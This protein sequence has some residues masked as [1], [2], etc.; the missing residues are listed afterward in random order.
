[1]GASVLVCTCPIVTLFGQNVTVTQDV[2]T[3]SASRFPVRLTNF[4]GRVTELRDV[5]RALE[6]HRLV[7]LVG[8]GGSGKTRLAIEAARS[9]GERRWFVDLASVE[10]GTGV[11]AELAAATDAPEGPGENPLDATVRR[12]AET[13]ALLLLDNCDQVVAACARTVDVLLRACPSL[14]VLATSREP[15]RVEGEHAWRVPP[16]SLP[17]AGESLDGDAVLLFLDRAGL[18]PDAA[19][20]DLEQ[21]H[22]ICR[23][24]DGMPLAIE[25]AASRATVLPVTDILTGLSDR[26]RLL[27]GGPRTTDTRQQSLAESIRWSYRLLTD[28]ERRVLQRLA[29]FRGPFTAE[30]TRA[31]AAGEGIDERDVLMLLANLVEKSFVVIDEHH[32][33]SRY[34]L[35]ETIRE[36]AVRQL[37]AQPEGARATRDRHLRYLRDS[38]ERIEPIFDGPDILSWVTRLESELPDI[39]AAVTWAAAS[40]NADDALRLTGALARY[41]WLT[42]RADSQRIVEAALAIDGGDD[43]W[44]A[45]ALICAS[46]AAG[47]RFDPSGIAFGSDAVGIAAKLDYP[48]LS[49]RANAQ[50]GWALA[51]VDPVQAGPHLLRACELARAEDDQW[52]L[53]MALIGLTGTEL[54]DPPS[55]RSRAEEALALAE[56]NGH[57][58]TAYPAGVWMT[59]VNMLQGRLDAAGEA[60]AAALRIAGTLGASVDVTW[61]KWMLTWRAICQGDTGAAADYE[62]AVSAAAEAGGNVLFLAYAAAA[63]GLL[64]YER[65]E[66]GEARAL[67]ADALPIVSRFPRAATGPYVAEIL[68]DADLHAGDL[69]AARAHSARANELA[70]NISSYWGR[71]RAALA[72]GRLELHTG[73]M[74][75]AADATHRALRLAR[76]NDDA[77]TIIDALELLAAITARRRNPETAVRLLGA[78]E[79]ERARLRY[80]RARVHTDDHEALLR[81]LEGELGE[82]RFARLWSEGEGLSVRDAVALARSRRGSR[83]R[84]AVGWDSL[85]PAELRVVELV[86]EGL[87]NPHIAERLFVTRD[88]VKGHVAAAFRKLGVSNRAELAA[89]AVRRGADRRG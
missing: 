60:A 73:A 1:M 71:S 49:A 84:P 89:E 83:G 9:A 78:T 69:S 56:R 81:D 14:T 61:L 33:A 46:S 7:S 51:Q 68:S 19:T 22:Q 65:G 16:L 36:Y 18:S 20:R 53:A 42:A 87:S 55:A 86:G 28:D 12:I 2:L 17:A 15:L 5:S 63:R 29:V 62:R 67:L 64:H 27:T 66:L 72:Q 80:A 48:E 59:L 50:L 77:I 57:Q 23:H 58:L 34:R 38:A 11:E 25:L 82:E 26:F 88:T 41:L 30:A 47:A 21:I 40:N 79:A 13:P 32:D 54:G 31:V 70:E 39:R 10:G 52:C 6:R 24:L 44:R 74:S 4:V 85:T 3:G 75:A 8:P 37:E 45:K 35:L 43:R 76:R